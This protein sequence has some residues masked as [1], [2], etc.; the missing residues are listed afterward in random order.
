MN[1]T[2]ARAK[3]TAGEDHSSGAQVAY[4]ILEL[5]SGKVGFDFAR[6]IKPIKNLIVPLY[7]SEMAWTSKNQV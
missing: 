3:T 5:V 2:S 7:K 1:K 4:R 6:Y